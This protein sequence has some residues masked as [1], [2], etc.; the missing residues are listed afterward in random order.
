MTWKFAKPVIAVT[1][2][3]FWL[4]LLQGALAGGAYLANRFVSDVQDAA[5]ARAAQIQRR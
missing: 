3:Y 5:S 1:V 2:V 4:V